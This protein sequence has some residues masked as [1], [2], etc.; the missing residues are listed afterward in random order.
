MTTVSKVK[1]GNPPRKGKMT[2]FTTE[3]REEAYKF[4]PSNIPYDNG[5]VKIGI[6]YQ[7]PRYVEQDSDMLV[8]Q[9]YLIEDPKVLNFHYWVNRFYWFVIAFIILTVWLTA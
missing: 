7:R 2:T 3:D 4:V 5:K 9:S 6:N 8:L 1:G